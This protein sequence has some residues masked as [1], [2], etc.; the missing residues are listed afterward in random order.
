MTE[1]HNPTHTTPIRV[2]G[3]SLGFDHVHLMGVLNVTPDSFSDGGLHFE[4]EPATQQAL[5]MFADGADWV[6]VGGESTRPGAEPVSEEEEL[7]RTIP[8]IRAIREKHDGLIS[9]DTT[10][11]AVAEAAIAAGADCINDISAFGFAP[12][13][14]G[15]VADLDVPVVLMHMRGVPK[16]MQE[17]EI[18]YDDIIDTLKSF[19]AERIEFAISAGVDEEQIIIDPGIGFGKTVAHNYSIVRRLHELRELGR[20]IL[21]GTSRKSFIGAVLDK[22]A[23]ERDFGT[24]ATVAFG[25]AFGADIVRV[26]NVAA[27]ADVLAVTNRVISG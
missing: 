22:P 23:A 15:L 8:A 3:Q 7:R 14:A 19:F 17:G 13:M 12:E 24:A 4:S 16:T 21:L 11:I 27:M 2:R 9:I 5:H 26:H 18:V 1:F 20:P 6:D 25:A 10:K